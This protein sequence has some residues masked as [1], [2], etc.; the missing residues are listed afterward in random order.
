M[1]L[2]SAEIFNHMQFGPSH[3]SQCISSTKQTEHV[4]FTFTQIFSYT[5]IQLASYVSWKACSVCTLSN[6][7]HCIR[8]LDIDNMDE[9]Y[10]ISHV[11]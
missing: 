5:C 7:Q 10:S 4:R 11:L 6:E 9:L 1:C 2:R 8:E 3:R